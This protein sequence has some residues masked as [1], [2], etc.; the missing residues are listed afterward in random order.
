[1]LYGGEYQAPVGKISMVCDESALVG[2]W[3]EGQKYFYAGICEPVIQQE[4]EIVLRVKIWL[5]QYFSGVKPDVS[6]IPLNPRGTEFQ[7]RVWERLKEIPCGQVCSYGQIADDTATKA[8]GS[9]LSARAVGSAVGRN[10]ILILIP[11]HRLIGADGSLTGYAAGIET[12][13]W[14]LRHEGVDLQ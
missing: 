1:M 13:Q 3:L 8:G 9:K 4:T 11:C 5:D 12:K 14:L 2:L 7:K 6:E 10:P